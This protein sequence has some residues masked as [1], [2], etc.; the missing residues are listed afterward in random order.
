MN[1]TVEPKEATE[2]QVPQ[3]TLDPTSLTR[4]R[5]CEKGTGDYLPVAPGELK[6]DAAN[7]PQQ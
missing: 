6:L 4:S 2:C 3:G 5:D 1:Y 7:P